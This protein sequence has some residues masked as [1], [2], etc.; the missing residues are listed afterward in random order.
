MTERLDDILSRYG[1]EIEI[2]RKGDEP[3]KAKAFFQAVTD[4]GKASPYDVTS[5]GTVDDRLWKCITRTG[6]ADGD[7]VSCRGVV[8]RVRTCAAVYLGRELSH[9]RGILAQEREAAV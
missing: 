1:Q 4:K 6:L 5:L 9:W 8:Y 2:L 3:R 7:L